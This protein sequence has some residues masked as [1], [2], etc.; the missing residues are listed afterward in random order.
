MSEK[1]E[2]PTD[3][4]LR[5][6]RNRG[7]VA[8]SKDFTQAV[9]VLGL[10][11]YLI[12]RAGTIRAELSAM[13]LLPA[14]LTELPFAAAFDILSGALLREAAVVVLPFIGL[15]IVLG[16]LAETMQVGVLFAFEAL[17]PSGKKLDVAANLKN[18]FSAK[19]WI[20]FAKSLLKVALLSLVVWTTLRGELADLLTI[21]RAGI[22]G[23]GLALGILLKNLFL[24][25]MVFY[26]VIA[27]FDLGLQRY[28]YRKDLRMTKEEVKREYKEMEGD[29]HIK[30]KRRHLHKELLRSNAVAAT[31]QA[32]V[33][34]TNPTHVA[35]ALRYDNEERTP[36]PIVLA[37]GEGALAA[38][39]RE[40]AAREGIPVVRNVPLARALLAT[41][42]IDRYI[43]I[44][45]IEP[46]AEVLQAIAEMNRTDR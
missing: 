34:V 35:I 19:S 17:K 41:A 33:L 6:A 31:K 23:V 29:P 26:A 3:K 37:K 13:I 7:Q 32:S 20:E 22:D 2:E 25:V 30:H 44:D 27:M 21:P 1:T 45:L 36:L 40:M 24:Q 39:M 12:A 28:R 10:F 5:D 14:T 4:K 18:M 11:G 16:V 15:V 43:P 38:A 46:V 42:Q 8:H 9:L